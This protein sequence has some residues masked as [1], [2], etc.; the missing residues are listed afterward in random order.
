MVTKRKQK[1]IMETYQFP[2][3]CYIHSYRQLLPNWSIFDNRL[4]FQKDYVNLDPPFESDPMQPELKVSNFD[5]WIKLHLKIK[6]TIFNPYRGHMVPL[7]V[8]KEITRPLIQFIY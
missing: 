1:N 7:I 2:F 4:S 5:Q 8:R 6:M 3:S